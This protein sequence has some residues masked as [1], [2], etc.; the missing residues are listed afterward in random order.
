MSGGFIYHIVEKPYYGKN[1]T[2]NNTRTNNK[3][4]IK[5]KI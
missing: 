3:T 1:H 4:R 5:L 2:H